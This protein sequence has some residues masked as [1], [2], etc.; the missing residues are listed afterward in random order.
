MPQSEFLTSFSL[1]PRGRAS[2]G[3]WVQGNGVSD[4]AQGLQRG[5]QRTASSKLAE[6]PSRSNSG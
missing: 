1:R 6:T 3:A 4:N 2:A 5:M